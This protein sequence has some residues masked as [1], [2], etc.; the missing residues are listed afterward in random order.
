MTTPAV[1]TP[2]T[3]AIRAA[4]RRWYG[5]TAAQAAR[6]GR[7][8]G[9]LAVPVLLHAVVTGSWSLSAG[10]TSLLVLLAPTAEVAW[11]QAHPAVTASQIE[12]APGVDA[13]P[14][15]TSGQP[16]TD[17]AV[18]D[19]PPEPAPIADEDAVAHAGYADTL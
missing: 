19:R 4:W 18:D 14:T 3:P 1:Q 15:D 17:P 10:Y 11:R 13:V 9:V 5:Q 7:L 2:T 12:A 16:I 6:F 8:F